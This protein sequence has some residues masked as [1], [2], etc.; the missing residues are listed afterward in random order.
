M[1]KRVQWEPEKEEPKRRRSPPRTGRIAIPD[2][3]VEYPAEIG[4]EKD[5]E[6]SKKDHK[7]IDWMYVYIRF[8][9][10]PNKYWMIVP[11]KLPVSWKVLKGGAISL[12]FQP[13]PSS[14]TSTDV[15]TSHEIYI[16]P[17]KTFTMALT[18]FKNYCIDLKQRGYVT[19][20]EITID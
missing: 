11:Q 3:D 18:R 1:P 8:K 13:K 17:R 14:L 5:R 20:Y 2:D 12:K 4:F 15:A 16:G 9:G 10:V 7:A 6:I 19:K